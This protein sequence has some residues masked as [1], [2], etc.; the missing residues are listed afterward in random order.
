MPPTQQS[1]Q[2]I[3][4]RIARQSYTEWPA[5]DSTPLYDR[6]SLAGL[7]D[8]VSVVP[9][10]WFEHDEHNSL[11]QSVCSVLITY[12][13]FETHNRY[14]ASTRYEKETLFRVFLL[15][16][17]HGWDHETALVDY[18]NNRPDL[19]NQLSLESVPDQST[20]W[21]SWNKRFTTDLCGTVETAARS[22]LIKTQNANAGV[23]VPREPERNVRYR[24]EDAED[25]TP[26]D[27]T[28]LSG[29]ERVTEHVNRVVFPAFSLRGEGCE[30]HKNAYWDLQTYFGLRENLA[31]NEGA[32]S[33]VYE[34]A[35][36]RT[37]LGHAHREHIRDLS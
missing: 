2:T 9:D 31:A 10:A 1:A 30:R 20:L 11:E 21:R 12:L 26:D 36:D 3:F 4:R 13:I 25:A 35:R 17:I 8:D 34:S 23:N 15:K 18:L 6:T 7:E 24:D 19:R 37:P 33:F 16:E 27:Q 22:I 32:R 5:Y 29:A 14:A 28:I